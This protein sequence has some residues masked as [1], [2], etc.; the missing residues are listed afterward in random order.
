MFYLLPDYKVSVRKDFG[1]K[2]ALIRRDKMYTFVLFLTKEERPHVGYHSVGKSMAMDGHLGF[3]L[4][5][6]ILHVT[7]ASDQAGFPTWLSNN[8]E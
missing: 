3:L 7:L 2:R 8:L 6:G 1:K 4:L 5:S